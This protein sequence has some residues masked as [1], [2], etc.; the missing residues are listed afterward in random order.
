MTN[1]LSNRIE[2]AERLT[3]LALAGTDPAT[4]LGA[5]RAFDDDA[6]SRLAAQAGE[7]TPSIQTRALV[8]AAVER[9]AT[10]PADPF[11]GLV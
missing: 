10:A 2:K 1:L 7:K 8:I 4:T 11:E 6:W 3:A 9:A 5:L